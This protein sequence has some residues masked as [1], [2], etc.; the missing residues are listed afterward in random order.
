MQQFLDSDLTII[1]KKSIP[2]QIKNI[3]NKVIKGSFVIQINDIRDISIP[4]AEQIEDEQEEN[5]HHVNSKSRTLRF[6]CTDGEEKFYSM[7]LVYCPSL[8]LDL[9]PGVKMS[10]KD[11]LIRRGILMLIPENIQILGGEVEKLKKLKKEKIHLLKTTKQENK[12]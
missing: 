9:S 4:L 8:S 3:Q 12:I 6:D 10:V 1:G 7:E 11:V 2:D 5:T